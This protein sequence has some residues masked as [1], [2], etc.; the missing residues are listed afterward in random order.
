MACVSDMSLL[1]GRFP[2]TQMKSDDTT[3]P[4]L[5]GLHRAADIGSWSV[6]WGYIDHQAL[7]PEDPGWNFC[8]L[9]SWV[10]DLSELIKE[11]RK[12]LFRVLCS[13]C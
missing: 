11:R 5:V 8:V 1:K 6:R 7:A 3:D 12:G 13:E 4:G 10:V 9:L 2:L